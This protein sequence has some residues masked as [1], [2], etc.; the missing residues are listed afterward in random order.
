[1]LVNTPFKRKIKLW[2]QLPGEAIA[3]FPCISYI[4]RKQVKKVTTSI[5]EEK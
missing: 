1:M 2:N 5:S 3:T 4:L